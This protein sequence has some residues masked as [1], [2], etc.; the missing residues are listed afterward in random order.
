M[1]DIA[2]A[3]AVEYFA[4]SLVSAPF[5]WFFYH[6]F[7]RNQKPP[8]DTSNRINSIRLAWF[9]MTR[10]EMFEKYLDYPV[11]SVWGRLRLAYEAISSEDK[12]F[13]IPEF[14]WLANDEKDNMEIASK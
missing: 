4:P 1:E 2:I 8:C 5:L 10:P 7:A 3:L 14:W 9:G 13:G 12:F 6:V 11:D